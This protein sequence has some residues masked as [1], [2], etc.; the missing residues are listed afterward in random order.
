MTG[1]SWFRACVPLSTEGKSSFVTPCNH[2]P[3]RL[4]M[5]LLQ[6]IILNSSFPSQIRYC[7][8]VSG[9]AFVMLTLPLAF[10]PVTDTV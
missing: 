6:C 3:F 7:V 8:S 1:I 10:F 9:S 2:C 5:E 4:C